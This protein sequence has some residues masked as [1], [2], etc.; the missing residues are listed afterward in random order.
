M[1]KYTAEK[2]TLIAARIK[3]LHENLWNASNIS[4]EIGS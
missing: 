1:H 3:T 4:L 2:D